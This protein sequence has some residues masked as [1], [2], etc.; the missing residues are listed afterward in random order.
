MSHHVGIVAEAPNLRAFTVNPHDI[1]MTIAALRYKLAPYGEAMVGKGAYV[2]LQVLSLPSLIVIN[3]QSIV[4]KAT[5]ERSGRQV[6]VKKSRVS[7]TV[8]RP[9]LQHETRVLQ[10]LNGQA[11]IPAVYG[12]GQ[13]EHFE[14]MAMELLGPSIAEQQKDGAG[15]M[16]KTVIQFMDQAVRRI[17]IRASYSTE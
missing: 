10:F 6:A 3:E 15:V 17:R 7:R 5:E 1:I 11:A 4:Y 13:L 2:S 16:V 9:T 14:Y 12:Y 8:K